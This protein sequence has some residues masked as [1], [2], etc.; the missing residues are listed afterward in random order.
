[1]VDVVCVVCDAIIQWNSI[2][3]RS[4]P[5]VVFDHFEG[6]R[7]KTSRCSCRTGRDVSTGQE[8]SLA[9]VAIVLLS[10]SWVFQQIYE[11]VAVPGELK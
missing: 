9:P 10:S 8:A 1:M 2:K 11:F 4:F 6:L 7:S 5:E 3:T